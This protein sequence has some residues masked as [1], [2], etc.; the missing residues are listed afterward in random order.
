LNSFTWELP[1]QIFTLSKWK[2]LTLLTLLFGR[3]FYIKAQQGGTLGFGEG[4]NG[5]LLWTHI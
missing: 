2:W 1:Y 5:R 4:I 3:G